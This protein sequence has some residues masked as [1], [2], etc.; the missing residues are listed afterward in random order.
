MFG[1]AIRLD[2]QAEPTGDRLILKPADIQ[3]VREI[4]HEGRRVLPRGGGSKP[5][6]SGPRLAGRLGLAE[7]DMTALAGMLEYEPG[8]LTF[9]ALAG[10][11]LLDILPLLASNGQYLPFDPLLVE[12]GATL[13][14]TVAAGASGSGRYHFGGVRDFLL[15]V[16]YINSDGQVVRGGGKVV[17]NAAGFDLPKL[18]VG[19]MG[20]L[21]VLVDLT[22]KV[23]PRPEAYVTLRLECANLQEALEALTRA[24]SARLD[25]DALDLEPWQAGYVLWVRMGGLA[26][27]LPARVD[28]LIDKLAQERDNTI[29]AMRGI[30]EERLWRSLRELSWAPPGWSLVRVPLT[31]ARI[32][33]LEQAAESA[34]QAGQTW[35][36]RYTSGGQVAWIAFEGPPQDLAGV[37]EVQGLGGQALF[38]FPGGPLLGVYP[39][40]PFFQRVKAALD[41]TNR[42]VEI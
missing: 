36:R 21:G 10:T 4:M 30:E 17:K 6:L 38:G 27:A 2:A 35:L 18:M 39:A 3:A 40:R 34:A 25:L 19:S 14:G 41:P 22:F 20:S 23:F 42:F 37:L 26:K 5:S 32:P 24:A 9:T 29:R 13:G 11:R 31:P 28:L 8:E 16:R 12:H 7:L 33:V 15:G 1:D